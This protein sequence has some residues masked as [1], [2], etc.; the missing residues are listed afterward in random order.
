MAW[1]S[2]SSPWLRSVTHWLGSLVGCAPARS[3]PPCPWPPSTCG[4]AST[5]KAALWCIMGRISVLAASHLPCA[6][7]V[8]QGGQQ[9]SG[10]RIWAAKVSASQITGMTL[11]CDEK[12]VLQIWRTKAGLAHQSR[13]R[14]ATTAQ[15][16]GMEQACCT[17]TCTSTWTSTCTSTSTGTCLQQINCFT[18]AS[19][20]IRQ[21][22]CAAAPLLPQASH[23]E[24]GTPLQR[25]RQRGQTQTR[26]AKPLPS[27]C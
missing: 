19:T 7:W 5:A 12:S 27:L 8:R 6:R 11:L 15:M 14:F 10:A 20:G 9:C 4:H 22:I 13:Q 3:L 25:R 24:T 1:A 17:S 26:S 16:I 23:W 21:Q 2:P 18:P